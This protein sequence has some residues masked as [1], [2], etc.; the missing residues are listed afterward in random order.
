MRNHLITL[1]RLSF[2]LLPGCNN[3]SQTGKQ[4][5]PTQAVEASKPVAAE[6]FNTL[7]YIKMFDEI[8][9]CAIS[10]TAVIRQEQGKW[11]DVTPT[12]EMGSKFGVAEFIDINNGWISVS[13]E[14]ATKFTSLRTSDGV[15][16]AGY[17]L[18]T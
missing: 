12:Q 10:P 7:S 2:V 15:N 5:P 8:S 14:G 17:G 6:I 1:I 13:K 18:S 9:G 4:E 16:L 3:L 11:V